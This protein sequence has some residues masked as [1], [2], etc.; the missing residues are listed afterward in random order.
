MGKIHFILTM[1]LLSIIVTLKV[2]CYRITQWFCV[3]VVTISVYSS[4]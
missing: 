4:L 2:L 1:I 3:E